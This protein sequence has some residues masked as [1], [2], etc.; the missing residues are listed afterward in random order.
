MAARRKLI[1]V[2]NRGPVSFARDDD[3]RPLA[4]RGGGGLVTALRSLVAQHDVTWIASAMSD[5]DRRSR[6]S[7]GGE[8]IEEQARDGS[9]VPAAPRRARPGRR[10]T[11][12]TTSSRTRR[13]GSCSTT[14]GSSRT[15]R[16]SITALHNAWDDG[17]WRREPRVRRRG[18]ARARARSRRDRLLPRLPPLPRAAARARA[19]ARTR[20]WRTSSTSRGRSRTTG[21]CCPRT[22]RRAVHDGLLANDVVGFH[23]DRW[24][25][26]FLR[27]AA[28][29]RRRRVRLRARALLV[30]GG[31]DVRRARG[32]SRSTR[33][34]SRSSQRATRRCSTEE[35]TL[36][37][38][39]PRAPDPARRPH[40]PVEERRARLPR[41]RALPRGHPEL[42]GRVGM[43]ALLDPSRQDIPEYAE[44]LGAIQ[45]EARARQRPLP[46]ATAGS[47]STSGSPTTS[48]SRSP[49][50]SSST[51]CS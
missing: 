29:P 7:A 16:T 46:D 27:R 39:R 42:H 1:V 40:R 45:R 51:C 11:G 19:G 6:P 18:A 8:A 20:A 24:R 44:Y 31:R 26:N 17:Y 15:R 41:V 38:T 47:R 43:L 37:E 36:V 2:S 49:R 13:S 30:H 21:T 4:R 14:S 32:R 25:R 5:E 35:E 10:T 50:T 33:T 28:R 12:T 9:T 23:T 3:G 22:I 34:S 48:R